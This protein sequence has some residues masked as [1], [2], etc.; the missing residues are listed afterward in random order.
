M[1]QQ[2]FQGNLLYLTLGALSAPLQITRDAGT[3][4]IMF[5]RSQPVINLPS[6]EETAWR[7]QVTAPPPRICLGIFFFFFFKSVGSVVA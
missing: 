3:F 5:G 4:S 7:L 1:H 6:I 2:V